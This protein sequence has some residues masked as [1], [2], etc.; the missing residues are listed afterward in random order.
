MSKMAI[1]M[2]M[3]QLGGFFLENTS[4]KPTARSNAKMLT[5]NGEIILV[6]GET[7]DSQLDVWTFN[8]G[9]QKWTKVKLSQAVPTLSG[10]SCFFFN[11][12]L[13]IIGGFLLKR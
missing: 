13:Q 1:Y 9:T 2:N 6:G 3:K 10:H 7:V 4:F 8:P 11:G 12:D 5:K